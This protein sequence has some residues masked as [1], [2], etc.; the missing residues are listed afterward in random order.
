MP[1][2]R[3]PRSLSM[4]SLL[5][6]PT[7]LMALVFVLVLTLALGALSL[8]TWL[9]FKRIESIRAHENRTFLQE[10]SSSILKEV[11]LQA[12]TGARAPVHTKLQAV[13]ANL[14]QIPVKGGPVRTYMREHLE[15][16]ENLLAQSETRP[17][18]AVPAALALLTEML[19]RENRIQFELLDT[20]YSDI[21]RES[22]LAIAAL[23]G[24]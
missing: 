5:L 15:Q 13:R 2:E 11:Q 19:E 6:R 21:R 20:V 4:K 12:A 9:D 22:R 10:Q 18:I 17:Q 16:L 8:F 3:D 14:A 24:F 1:E 23:I 7:R